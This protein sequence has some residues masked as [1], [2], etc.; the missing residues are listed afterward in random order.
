MIVVAASP[1]PARLIS[2]ESVAAAAL[3]ALADAAS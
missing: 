2:V 3:L 1:L